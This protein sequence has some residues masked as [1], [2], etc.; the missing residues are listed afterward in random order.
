MEWGTILPLAI[1]T[2]VVL[3]PVAF[4]WYINVGGIYIAIKRR[5]MAKPLKKALPNLTCTIDTERPQ[6]YVCLIGRCVPQN[7]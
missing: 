5:R 4:I 3:F 2:L 7:A 6:G 1:G